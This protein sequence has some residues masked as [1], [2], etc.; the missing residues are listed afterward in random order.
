M[1]QT[2]RQHYGYYDYAA[3]TARAIQPERE[4]RP[5]VRVIPGTRSENPALQAISPA[6]ARAF[7]LAIVVLVLVASLCAARVW[8]S[9]S[10]VS[11]LEQ[12]NALESTLASAQASTNELEI[13]HSILSSATRIEQEAANLG[14][15]A[16]SDVKFLKVPVL[17][18][19]VTYSNGSISLAGTIRNIEEYAAVMS[20]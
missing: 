15:V 5:D 1:A 4:T 16:P 2:V 13:Q 11:M 12:A 8:L 7:K 3:S 18:K 20:S 19:V 10:T 17:G 6:F 14:M 9:S